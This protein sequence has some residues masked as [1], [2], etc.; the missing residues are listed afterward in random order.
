ML[1]AVAM[2]HVLLKEQWYFQAA[3]QAHPLLPLS[4][5]LYNHPPMN[6]NN[7][8]NPNEPE[9]KSESEEETIRLRKKFRE[10]TADEIMKMSDQEFWELF[11]RVSEKG[12]KTGGFIIPSSRMR[13]RPGEEEGE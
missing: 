9:N 1:G 11:W 5:L 13:P 6:D 7:N 3:L 4:S 8:A 12:T 10:L 2:Y